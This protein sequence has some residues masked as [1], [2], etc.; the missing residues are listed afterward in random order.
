MRPQSDAAVSPVGTATLSGSALGATGLILEKDMSAGTPSL[1][2]LSP[3]AHSAQRS[4]SAY[5]GKASAPTCQL[6]HSRCQHA[7]APQAFGP[8]Y[9]NLTLK[10]AP[11]KHT[12]ECSVL[13]LVHLLQAVHALHSPSSLQS[14]PAQVIHDRPFHVRDDGE[15]GRHGGSHQGATGDRIPDAADQVDSQTHSADVDSRPELPGANGHEPRR[16]H[17]GPGGKTDEV[18]EGRIQKDQP[19]WQ[20][21]GSTRQGSPSARDTSPRRSPLQ[22]A[23]L[24][25]AP[26]PVE[27]T[28]GEGSGWEFK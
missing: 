13:F 8:R 18:A 26:A 23:P 15:P 4:E 5:K 28:P 19:S 2:L 16:R 24:R 27:E 21:Q 6:C 9:C 22:P 20:R 14:K 17:A 12:T 10:G 25:A 1:S 11:I 3:M 7:G